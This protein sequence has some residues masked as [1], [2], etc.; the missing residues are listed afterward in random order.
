MIVSAAMSLTS[1]GTAGNG[2]VGTIGLIEDGVLICDAGVMRSKGSE[3]CD[4]GH[5]VSVV[6]AS[7][8]RLAVEVFDVTPVVEALFREVYLPNESRP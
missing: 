6:V 4:E 3:S 5:V 8:M 7:G 1:V 2:C